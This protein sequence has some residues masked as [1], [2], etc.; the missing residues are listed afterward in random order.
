MR[1]VLLA[2]G[3]VWL[4]VSTIA[5]LLLALGVLV[6]IVYFGYQIGGP[7]LAFVAFWLG[8]GL[9]FLVVHVATIPIKLVGVALIALGQQD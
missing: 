6:L 4:V 7:I 3:Q 2:I 5:S 1:P 9:A 8:G